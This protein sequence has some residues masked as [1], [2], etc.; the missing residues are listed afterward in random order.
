M[1]LLVVHSYSGAPLAHVP[2]EHGWGKMAQKP[3]F[4]LSLVA[5][6][7]LSC[8]MQGGGIT[9]VWLAQLLISIKGKKLLTTVWLQLQPVI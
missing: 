6:K 7:T 4:G 3:R 5:Y 8:I 9:N 1:V 2:W